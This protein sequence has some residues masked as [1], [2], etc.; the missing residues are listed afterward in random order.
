VINSLNNGSENFF[1]KSSSFNNVPLKKNSL[2]HREITEGG[3]LRLEFSGKV[4]E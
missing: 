4:E 1:I 3:E 2:T